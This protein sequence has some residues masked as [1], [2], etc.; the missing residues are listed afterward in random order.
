MYT[1][2]CG[3][4]AGATRGLPSSPVKG[5]STKRYF[6]VQIIFDRLLVMTAPAPVHVHTE[7]A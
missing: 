7:G 4:Y 6:R 1:V 2:K 5:Q 3:S